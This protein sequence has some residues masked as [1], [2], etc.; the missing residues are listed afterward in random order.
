MTDAPEDDGDDAAEWVDITTLAS[1]HDTQLNTAT[2]GIRHRR[3][4][5]Q[6]DYS[7]YPPE[8]VAAMA[9]ED[10]WMPGHPPD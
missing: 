8:V 2:G 7:G 9:V 3:Q 5:P 4:R 10:A 6:I 1:S